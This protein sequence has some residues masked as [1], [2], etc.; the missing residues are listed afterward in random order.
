MQISIRKQANS[1]ATSNAE[2]EKMSFLVRNRNRT[3]IEAVSLNRSLNFSKNVSSGLGRSTGGGQMQQLI[4]RT[5]NQEQKESRL[6]YQQQKPQ[7]AISMAE[8]LEDLRILEEQQHDSKQKLEAARLTKQRRQQQQ[9]FLE[10]ALD[11]LKYVNGL[12]RAELSNFHNVLS[13]SQRLI[14]ESRSISGRA[15]DN[16]RFFD[17]KLQCFLETK[18]KLRWHEL[19]QDLCFESIRK[20]RQRLET[21]I[22]KAEHDLEQ[23]TLMLE[24]SKSRENYL[25][26]SIYNSNCSQQEIA[27]NMVLARAH[28]SRK[29]HVLS[30]LYGKESCAQLE[31]ENILKSLETNCS[32]HEESLRNL[33]SKVEFASKAREAYVSTKGRLNE[34]LEELAKVVLVLKNE[35]RELQISEG[36]R[37]DIDS[38][39]SRKK[40]HLDIQKVRDSSIAAK[41]ASEDEASAKATIQ[42]SIEKCKIQLSDTISDLELEETKARS[43]EYSVCQALKEGHERD[44]FYSE[45]FRELDEMKAVVDKKNKTLQDYHN[46][47]ENEIHSS[48]ILLAKFLEANN[49]RRSHINEKRLEREE[50]EEKIE[51]VQ[52]A[53]KEAKV[54]DAQKIKNGH[55]VVSDLLLEFDMLRSSLEKESPSFTIKSRHSDFQ[56]KCNRVKQVIVELL[57]ANPLLRGMASG[58]DCFSYSPSKDTILKS[59]SDICMKRIESATRMKQVLQESEQKAVAES[60]RIKKAAAALEK[61]MEEARE[62]RK[63]R[64]RIDSITQ[65]SA[66]E[67]NNDNNDDIS[68]TKPRSLLRSF[69]IASY[70]SENPVSNRD[71]K[72]QNVQANAIEKKVHWR[73]YNRS[74]TE[75]SRKLDGIVDQSNSQKKRRSFGS[76]IDSNQDDN[77]GKSIPKSSN[78]TRYRREKSKAKTIS[79]ENKENHGE[80]LGVNQDSHSEEMKKLSARS[81]SRRPSSFRTSNIVPTKPTVSKKI[82]TKSPTEK[83]GTEDLRNTD[84]LHFCQAI[85]PESFTKEI[86]KNSKP[87]RSSKHEREYVSKKNC[88]VTKY[89]NLSGQDNENA[90]SMYKNA[91]QLKSTRSSLAAYNLPVGLDDTSKQMKYDKTAVNHMKALRANKEKLG[92]VY[93]NESKMIRTTGSN[94]RQSSTT[95]SPQKVQVPYKRKQEEQQEEHSMHQLVT[96]SR[97]SVVAKVAAPVDPPAEKRNQA[98]LVARKRPRRESFERDQKSLLAG[99]VSQRSKLEDLGRDFSFRFL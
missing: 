87:V 8:V 36:N 53:Y 69:S 96:K 95:A 5:S 88:D 73:D 35:A 42:D 92:T 72:D 38:W 54:R 49:I 62:R 84:C 90:N 45:L 9:T 27:Q 79:S 86:S 67:T 11:K 70:E 51:G 44:V 14:H 28:Y 94:E 19:K 24:D 61:S 85:S 25:R 22:L 30:D 17:K 3:D 71:A 6:R 50:L 4:Y 1:I 34:E 7:S 23:E 43:L 58:N 76:V 40:P 46:S 31:L 66:V 29:D 60:K 10:Q 77:R 65:I 97:D 56:M 59:L 32:Y 16:L 99:K 57:E 33:T 18:P 12:K 15:G 64:H 80:H 81:R 39:E 63:N 55:F 13:E 26:N 98:P 74:T 82:Q 93:R 37:S 2:D 89:K 52:A 41:K 21:L 20:N 75:G 48:N 83:S 91:S 68:A 78:D 47:H